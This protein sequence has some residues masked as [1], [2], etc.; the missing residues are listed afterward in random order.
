MYTAKV[1][2]SSISWENK[3]YIQV[4]FSFSFNLANRMTEAPLDLV[5]FLYPRLNIC[6]ETNLVLH[7]CIFYAF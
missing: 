3:T 6:F 4:A 7:E 5:G 1:H 2:E